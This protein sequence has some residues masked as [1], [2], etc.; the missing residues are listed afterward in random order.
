MFMLIVIFKPHLWC[1][2]TPSAF[3]ALFLVSSQ[4]AQTGQRFPPQSPAADLRL[5]LCHLP[6]LSPWRLLPSLADFCPGFVLSVGNNV[7]DNTLVNGNICKCVWRINIWI[8]L[9]TGLSVTL[10]EVLDELHQVCW[11]SDD[12]EV[13]FLSWRRRKLIRNVAKVCVCVCVGE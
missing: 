2:Q 11:V 4:L 12:F 9:N 5:H 8:L 7:Q 3:P 10:F 13:E 6:R 1:C